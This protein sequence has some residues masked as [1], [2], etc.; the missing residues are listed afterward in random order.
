M[1]DI[2]VRALRE[3]ELRAYLTAV[4]TAFGEEIS[5]A[6]FAANERIFET[7]RVFVA[8]DGDRIVGGGGAFSFEMTVPGGESVGAA[9]VTAVG[10]MPTY[11][12]QGL[13]R[14]VMAELLADSR[15]RG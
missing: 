14:R 10:T 15:R 12:R 3:G 2:D 1:A 11:R 6:E 4:S 5:D 13:M 8:A 9:G 7:D